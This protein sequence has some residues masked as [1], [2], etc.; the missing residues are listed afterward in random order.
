MSENLAW[1]LLAAGAIAGKVSKA[2][3]L[4]STGHVLAVGSR[5]QQTADEFAHAYGVPRAYGTYEALLADEDVDVVYVSTPHPMH[6]E[7]A[8]KAAEAGKHIL[9]EKPLTT[10][11]AEAAQVID[12]AR[13]N[14][15]FLME[16]FAYRVHPYTHRL[17]EL[18]RSGAIGR[19]GLIQIT[20]SFDEALSTLRRLTEHALGGG[21]ILDIGCYGTSMSRLLAGAALGLPFAEPVEVN[22]SGH[23]DPSDRVDHYAAATLKFEGGIVAQLA[24]GVRLAQENAV[25]V[26]GRDGSITVSQPLWVPPYPEAGSRT[27]T[28]RRRDDPAPTEI[29]VEASG[30]LFASQ[31]DEVAARVRE[32]QSPAISWDDTLGNM[33][34][35]D[36]WRESI[37]LR[38][39]WEMP[40]DQTAA[41]VVSGT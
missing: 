15:V 6:A 14:D 37:G 32:R 21:G 27:L 41:E 10:N 20:F 24:C 33:R 7:W 2:I 31:I 39:D 28:L 19:L 29:A 11:Y 1:G 8:I 25:R 16:A 17:V 36:R 30:G 38:Y 9:C 12:A 34:T 26:Y 23:I 5:S 22:G 40:S 3:E 35:L 13:R 18:V 4:S